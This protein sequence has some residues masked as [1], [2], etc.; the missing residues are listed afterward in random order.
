MQKEDPTPFISIK[1]MP[2]P[3]MMDITKPNACTS[4]KTQGKEGN[5]RKIYCECQFDLKKK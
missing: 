3:Q 4:F 1:F 2:N 5:P